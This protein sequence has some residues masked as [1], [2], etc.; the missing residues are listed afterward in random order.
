FVSTREPV[1][2]NR[3]FVR[4]DANKPG[5]VEQKLLWHRALGDAASTLNGTLDDISEQFR[6]S[7]RAISSTGYL[8]GSR[9]QPLE[10]DELWD[11]CRSLARPRLEDLAQRIVPFAT[12]DD[13]VLPELQ[14]NLLRQLAA[15]VRHRMKVYETW[16]FAA[17]GRRGL[18][19]SALFTG[20]S[21]TGKTMAA[22]V[23]ARELR[24][25]LYRIDL[26][27]VVSKYI[28]ETEKN[29]KQVFDA[30][31]EG[32]S[33]LLFDEADALFGKRSEVKDSHDR[34]ANIEVSYLLQRMEVYRGLAILTTNIKSVLDTA[35][36]RR[37]RFI[38]QFPFPDVAQRVKI[39]E[40]VFPAHTPTEHL[41]VHKL[42]RLN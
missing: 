37:I 14:R 36:L 15:Q 28:G 1:R 18:G 13:L 17:R 19:V 42:A 26:S 39:W 41:D 25:D 21:G 20:A 33:V 4:L 23:L 22:E 31:E 12:W 24:L 5:P 11:A 8:L 34:Y 29:L 27:S 16:G 40:G 3:T 9:D 2:L 7:A 38:V 6:L 30:A 10:A 35:F 32:G